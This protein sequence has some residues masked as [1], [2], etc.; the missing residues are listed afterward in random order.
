[1]KPRNRS[2]FVKFL[3]SPFS[4]LLFVVVLSLLVPA[5]WRMYNKRLDVETR[6][7]DSVRRYDKID[8]HK[9]NVSKEI[10]RLSTDEGMIG[11]IR[12][13]FHAIEPGEQ[14]AVVINTEKATNTPVGEEQNYPKNDKNIFERFIGIFGF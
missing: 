12:R 11:E 8:Q 10:E 13:K 9:T 1:M 4:V 2:A 14:V 6:L 5:S 3:A 7:G